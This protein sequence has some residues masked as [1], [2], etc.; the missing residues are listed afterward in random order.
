[1]D[2][3]FK[4]IE[5]FVVRA[6]KEDS[7]DIPPKLYREVYVELSAPQRRAYEEMRLEM[8]AW[9]GEHEDQALVAPAVIAKLQRL[10]MLAVGYL[11]YNDET[12][13]FAMREPSTKLDAIMQILEDNPDEAFVVFSQFKA[14]LRL[15]AK[16]LEAKNIGYG[17]F[18]GDDGQAARSSAKSA[19][20]AGE[21]RVFLSTIKSGGVGVDGLQHRCS[22]VIFLDRDW[23]PMINQQAEDRLHRGGQVKHVQVI[24][25]MGRNTVDLGRK[26]RI[27]EKWTWIR[28]LL[29]DIK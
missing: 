5:P 27:E 28:K 11:E 8:I 23:S 3:G 15:L 2:K 25:I 19:F 18:T 26:Q 1:V 10:Q 6:L 20:I 29:G 16:R 24:D 13:K 9:V 22:N 14:P 21:A 12:G 4:E 7:M 17:S